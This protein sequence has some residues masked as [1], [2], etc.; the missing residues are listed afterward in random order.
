MSFIDTFIETWE[1]RRK[2]KVT[3]REWWNWNPLNRG[4]DFILLGGDMGSYKSAALCKLGRG[5]GEARTKNQSPLESIDMPIGTYIY[6]CWLAFLFLTTLSLCLSGLTWVMNQS[7][8]FRYYDFYEV[9][10]IT[11][12]GLFNVSLKEEKK[13]FSRLEKWW[14]RKKWTLAAGPCGHWCI[15]I[16]QKLRSLE[17]RRSLLRKCLLI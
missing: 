11:V 12:Q 17:S 16:Q 13:I 15:E 9:S 6:V 14:V 4:N 7:F 3:V 2:G 10:R 5:P 1:K 8:N